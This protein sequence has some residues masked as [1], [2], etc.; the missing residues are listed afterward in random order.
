MENRDFVINYRVTNAGDGT[1]NEVEVSDR[2]DAK[3]FVTVDNISEE[4]HVS[5]R[6]DDLAPGDSMTFNVT[7]QP[8]LYG[9]YDSTRA[10]IKYSSNALEMDGVETEYRLG[11]STSLGRIK[12]ISNAEAVRN[13]SYFIKEWAIFTTLCSLVTLF[14][15]YKWLLSRAE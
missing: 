11:Y 3:S 13:V 4:G 8:K 10:R 2:Y 9:T 7:V 12:I 5:F 6:I 15:L 14:P 1:A